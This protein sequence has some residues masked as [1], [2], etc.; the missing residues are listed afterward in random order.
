MSIVLAERVYLE[1]KAS[2][3]ND[4]ATLGWL[5]EAL[6]HSRSQG[7]TEVVDH[8]ESIAADMVFEMEMAARRASLLS[9]LM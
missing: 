5:V 6:E 3:N 9:R 2:M 4:S 1:L 7:Q 8:L